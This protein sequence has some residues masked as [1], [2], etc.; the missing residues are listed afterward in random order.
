LSAQYA[1]WRDGLYFDTSALSGYS[2]T[3]ASL[4]LFWVENSSVTDFAVTITNGQPTYPHD[5][6]ELGDYNKANY[7]VTDGGNVNTSTFSGATGWATIT[8]NATGLTW[9]DTAG[10]TKL[11]LRSS[12]DI[13]GTTPTG[14]EYVVF[15]SYEYGASYRPYLDVTY[16]AEAPSGTMNAASN[17]AVTSARLN[18]TV[19]D[20]GGTG[21]QVRWG[22]GTT[23]QTSGNFTSYDTVT[24]WSTDNYT[25]GEHPYEDIASLTGGDTYYARVQ[26]KNTA[27][28]VTSDE[29]SFT[30]ESS[31]NPPTGVIGYPS[32][33][34]ITLS[35]SKSS[36]AD[37]TVIR[38]SLAAFPTD[39]TTGTLVYSGAD[40]TYE[41]DSLNSGQTYFY[42]LWGTS[43]DNW[44]A[45]YTTYAMTTN[46]F[47][48]GS[49]DDLEPPSMWSRWFSPPDYTNLSQL[50]PVYSTVNGVA[51]SLGMPRNIAWQGMIVFGIVILTALVLATTKQVAA[52][53][54]VAL[55]GLG[56]GAAMHILP[57]LWFGFTL[58]AAIAALILKGK[59][60]AAGE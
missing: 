13:A 38:F 15:A 31:L 46:A 45:S 55:A 50:E 48:L 23:T 12:R 32:E 53:F 36:G 52:A 41:H 29:I 28:N 22:Y 8:L 5:P 17:V 49:G 34:S 7:A 3:D 58:F 30:T 14:N 10:D 56:I 43:G 37:S 57:T 6:L 24:S 11:F 21:C 27:G 54:I 19:D 18:A 42:S 25:T 1:V 44:S 59:M 60:H 2:V 39:N 9:I 20:D 35:W 47:T 33:T 16:T 51:D 26:I 40:T 4:H